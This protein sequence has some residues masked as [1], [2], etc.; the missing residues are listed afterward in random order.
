MNQ[1]RELVDEQEPMSIRDQCGLL[2]LSRSAYYYECAPESAE[3]L[4]LMRRLDE[5]HLEHPVYGSRKLT[6][7]LE[8]EGQLVNRKRVV[9]LLRL[10]GIE[11]IYP[12]TKTSEPGAGHRIYPYLLKGLE[13]KGPDEVWCAD[14]TYIPLQQGFMYLVAVMDWW[15]R[16]VLAWEISNTL[17]SD[18]C[19]R[20]WERALA[21]GRRTPDISNTDQGSQ[22]TSEAY[23]EAVE[24]AGA[25]VSMD[26][27]G[28]WIDNRFIERLWRSVKYEDVYLR[29]YL[30]GLD[31]G[32]GLGQWFADYNESRPHQALNYACPGD[33]Y[34]NPESHGARTMK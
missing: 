20:A 30:D 28:R 12:K 3:N 4:A 33:V 26:G 31:L 13:I 8:Q 14:I 23:I 27:R 1:L 21:Q 11:A 29:D 16:C 18:F 24:S 10:M 15:S 9:R 25:A 19:V 22:F 6:K 34:R 32:R 2:G 7:V 17:E 5:L